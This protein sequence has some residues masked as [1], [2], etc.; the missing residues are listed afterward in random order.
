MSEA[1]GVITHAEGHPALRHLL[2]VDDLS[3]DELALVLDLARRPPGPDGR[4]PAVCSGQTVA[5]VFEKAS[6]RTRSSSEV[7]WAQ[8]G[9]HP[10]TI[11]GDEVGIDERE[12]AEDVALTLGCFHRVIGA[13]VR[14]HQTLE[15]FVAALG[16]RGLNVPVVNLLSDL[17]HPVQALADVLTLTEELGPL[18]GPEGPVVAWVGD[19]NNVCRSFVLA[20]AMSGGRVRVG[21]PAGYGL[22]ESTVARARSF[23]G[24]VD[25]VETPEEAVRG[26]RAVYTDV[27]TSMGQEAERAERLERFRGW[28]VDERLMALAS[29]EAIFLHCL[30]AHRGEEVARAVIDGRWSR[31]WAQAAHRLDAMRG[32]WWWLMDRHAGGVS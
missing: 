26:A 17:A 20:V 7:A 25:L 27:W 28:T 19:G 12:S 11:R 5:L 24:Q 1:H 16:G 10:V 23:G 32:L 22:D 30:P 2:D 18:G 4:W 29:P 9:G 15:R 8:L 3:P 6:A 13:R 14:S 31:V 21:C